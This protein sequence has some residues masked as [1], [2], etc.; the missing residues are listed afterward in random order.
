MAKRRRG[1]V[2]KAAKKTGPASCDDC[3]ARIVYITMPTGRRVPVDPIPND[4]GT[5]CG[6]LIGT[7]LHGYVISKDHPWEKP[8]T[9]YVAHFATCSDRPRPKPKPP[10]E[11]P[12]L[13]F[14]L[15]DR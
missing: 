11:D 6:R 12:L 9:R 15:E 3:Q 14:D 13:L 7:Q 1:R 4:E 8:Y 5:V 10:A 2:F